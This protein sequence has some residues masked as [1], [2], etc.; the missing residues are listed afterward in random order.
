MVA[1]ELTPAEVALAGRLLARRHAIHRAAEPLIAPVDAAGAVAAELAAEGASGVVADDGFMIGRV[2]TSDVFGPGAWI[3]P[4]GHAGAPPEV[5][6]DLY[7]R[8]AAAWDADSIQ[9]HY[10]LVP[11]IAECLDVWYRLGFAQ[12]HVEGCRATQW[13][14]PLPVVEGVTIRRGGPADLD[15]AVAIDSLIHDCQEQAPSFSGY[16]PTPERHR[17]DWEETLADPDVRYLIAARGAVVVGHTVS[18]PA[19]PSFGVA[20][21]SHAIASTAVVPQERGR[22][23]GALLLAAVADQAQAAGAPALFTNWRCTNLV[24]SRYWTAAGFRPT[25]VRL[26]RVLRSI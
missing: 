25:F 4:A 6:H 12:M 18:W 21:G 14:G 16:R 26:A 17:T 7:T 9:R 10:V 15:A 22:G 5:L 1:R 13:P 8:L 20:P 3:G 24:A 23:L 2:V 11:A 19:D